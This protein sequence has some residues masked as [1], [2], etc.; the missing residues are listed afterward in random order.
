MGARYKPKKTVNSSYKVTEKDLAL[1]IRVECLMILAMELYDMIEFQIDSMGE[2]ANNEFRL[3]K[4][5]VG[6]VKTGIVAEDED[7]ESYQESVGKMLDFFDDHTIIVWDK[8]KVVNS[9]ISIHLS[10]Y[11]KLIMKL[12]NS[13]ASDKLK[14]SIKIRRFKNSKKHARIK[15]MMAQKVIKLD[16]CLKHF[17]ESS[18]LVQKFDDYVRVIITDDN[19]VIEK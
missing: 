15:K 7:Q 12:Y 3:Y 18:D 8:F 16:K 4:S 19:I 2:K 10:E 1:G 5:R 9:V 14:G 17:S 6:E 11:F 13:T